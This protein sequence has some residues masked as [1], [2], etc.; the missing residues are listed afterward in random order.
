MTL[1]IGQHRHCCAGL[2]KVKHFSLHFA[3]DVKTYIIIFISIHFFVCL[4]WLVSFFFCLPANKKL[5]I[6]P[7][8]HPALQSSSENF[9]LPQMS[10]GFCSYFSQCLYMCGFIMTKLTRPNQ[11]RQCYVCHETFGLSISSCKR[12]KFP[13]L[14]FLKLYL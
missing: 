1:G 8:Q 13:T 2:N 7:I 3:V 5:C 6:C 11:L 9:L 12:W 4:F 10:F 14:F